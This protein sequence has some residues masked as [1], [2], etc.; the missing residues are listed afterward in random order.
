M[1]SSWRSNLYTY[2]LGPGFYYQ[3]GFV[4]ARYTLASRIRSGTGTGLILTNNLA[5]SGAF[6]VQLP[7]GMTAYPPAG[8]I[9]TVAGHPHFPYGL[10]VDP[11]LHV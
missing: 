8:R 6:V 9:G 5:P 3:A 10:D 4:L 11:D 1:E 7:S 2:G